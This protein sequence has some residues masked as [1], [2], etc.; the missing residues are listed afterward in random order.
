M[1]KEIITAEKGLCSHTNIP[2]LSEHTIAW[3]Y[4]TS[5]DT[6]CNVRHTYIKSFK[7][8]TLF[9]YNNISVF[10]YTLLVSPT[11]NVLTVLSTSM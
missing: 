6:S 5:F 10:Y 2:Y 1:G 7:L 3:I 4:I 8:P 9:I 11:Y